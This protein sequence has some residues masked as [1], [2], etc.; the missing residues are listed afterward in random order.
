MLSRNPQWWE[1]RIY[2]RK[3][4]QI[5]VYYAEAGEPQGYLIYDVKE[6]KMTVHELV[7]L[8]ETARQ[9]LWT[10]I[11]NHDSM[12]KEVTTIAP[13]DDDLISILDNPRIKHEIIPYFMARIVDIEAFTANYPFASTETAHELC[14]R[15]ADRDAEWNNGI[16]RLQVNPQGVGTLTRISDQTDDVRQDTLTCSIQTLT[17]MLMGYQRPQRLHQLGRIVGNIDTVHIIERI[18]P[19][20]QTFLYDFF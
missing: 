12:A 9:S 6:S 11:A 19:A 10:F 2:R 7:C 13:L 16:F 4:G 15:V 3:K 18:V 8:N 20:A 14:L 1:E 5:A 17:S